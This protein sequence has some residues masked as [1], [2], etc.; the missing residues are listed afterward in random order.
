[1]IWLLDTN[2]LAYILNGEVG[3][4]NRANEAGRVGR[5]VT[6]IVVVAELL[7]G[8]ERSTKRETNLRHLEKALEPM[9]IVPLSLGAAAH[10]GRLKAELRAKGITKTDLDL[11]IAA[12]AIDL[13]A[14]LVT[15]DRALTD[16]SIPG[17]AVENWR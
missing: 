17:L 14:T 1:V 6:S 8:V 2:T 15:N 11:L 16:G 7:Y 12:T 9:E 13:G 3:V 10:F 5:I 4:R